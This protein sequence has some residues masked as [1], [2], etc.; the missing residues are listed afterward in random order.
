MEPTRLQIC[1]VSISNLYEKNFIFCR[2]KRNIYGAYY[3]FGYCLIDYTQ[4]VH[5]P[6]GDGDNCLSC[7]N[8]R[9]C[10]GLSGKNR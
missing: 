7:P 9:D 1:N 2:W 8:S 5:S 3:C 4:A 6:N 10:D